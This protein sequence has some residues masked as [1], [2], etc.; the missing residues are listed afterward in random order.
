MHHYRKFLNRQLPPKQSNRVKPDPPLEGGVVSVLFHYHLEL[1]K[2]FSY[3]VVQ[4]AL[5]GDRGVLL[6]DQG[7]YQGVGWAEDPG[8]EWEAALEVQKIVG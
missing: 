4:G 5:L 1:C 3:R 7:V 8:D 6:G 2:C